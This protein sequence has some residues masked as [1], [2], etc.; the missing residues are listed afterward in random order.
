[1]GVGGGT[2]DTSSV[3][4]VSGS[5]FVPDAVV[6]DTTATE[7]PCAGMN[8]NLPNVD[9]LVDAM[10]NPAVGPQ[11]GSNITKGFKGQM[12]VDVT[13]ITEPYWKAGLCPVNV[14]WHLGAEHYSVGE[15]DENG[16]GVREIDL[17]TDGAAGFGSFQCHHY[18][19]EDPKFTRPYEFKHC[20]GME[21]GQT[22]E[23]HW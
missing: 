10:T 17:T 18:D 19:E 16:K 3:E 22:Y 5:D 6:A 1:M 20:I 12:S 23:V 7:N 9:C 21:V 11:A 2:A 8:P 14:H 4:F 15:F 13:P